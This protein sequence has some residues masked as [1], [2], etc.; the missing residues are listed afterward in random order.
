MVLCWEQTQETT[1]YLLP[2]WSISYWEFR[3]WF[4]LTIRLRTNQCKWINLVLRTFTNCGARS[5]KL[6]LI[7][8]NCVL[9]LHLNPIPVNGDKSRGIQ[10]ISKQ[11]FNGY[12]QMWTANHSSW[13]FPESKGKSSEFPLLVSG[14]FWDPGLWLKN[15]KLMH[16]CNSAIEFL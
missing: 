6:I 5:L 3:P 10:Q 8:Q 12:I 13:C 7:A 14:K 4:V 16:A 15:L 11:Q 1:V 2:N 9:A